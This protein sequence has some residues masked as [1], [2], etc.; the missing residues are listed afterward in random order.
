[1]D[2]YQKLFVGKTVTEIE[3]WAAKYTSSVN[4][5][6][7]KDGSTNADEKAKYDALT[8]E[9][10]AMLADVTTAATMSL[11]DAHGD[12]LSAIKASFTNKIAITIKQHFIDLF[13]QDNIVRESSD[14]C[15]LE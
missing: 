15:K 14:C 1:M 13:V 2:R 10:K 9:E 11:K 4:G 6:P 7:L 3:A 12:I 5:K 8:K